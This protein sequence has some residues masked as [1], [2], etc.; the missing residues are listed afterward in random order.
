MYQEISQI[1]GKEV[2]KLN[3]FQISKHKNISKQISK[4]C[5][6]MQDSIEVGQY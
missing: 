1:V 4:V 6:I 2:S 3:T 5:A